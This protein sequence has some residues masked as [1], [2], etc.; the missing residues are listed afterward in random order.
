MQSTLAQRHVH[1]GMD[2]VPYTKKLPR[3]QHLLAYATLVLEG[4]FEQLSYAGRLCLKAGDVLINPTFDRHANRML[5]QGLVLV[6]LP[7]CEVPTVGGVYRNLAIDIA[8][9]VAAY[10]PV[11]ASEI[12]REEVLGKAYSP[13][14]ALDWPDGLALEL[15]QNRKLNLSRWADSHGLTREYVWRCFRDTFGVG[16]AHFRSEV[17]ARAAF[18][19][20]VG[21]SEPLSGIAADLGFSDQP[22]MTRMVTALA[23]SAWRKIVLDWIRRASKRARR[24]SPQKQLS[25]PKRP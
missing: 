7:W 23:R 20:I 14:T 17:N 2:R 12:L 3:H 6:R 21:S 8:R 18:L 15:G 11:E 16:P 13:V 9:R 19:R 25:A 22:H 4:R 5:S 1:H 24:H 10:D